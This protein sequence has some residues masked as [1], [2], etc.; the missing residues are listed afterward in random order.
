MSIPFEELKDF[1][2]FKVKEFNTNSFIQDDPISL[3]HRF[4]RKEDI[5]IVGFLVSTIAW[6]N[7]R[8]IIKSGEKLL[9]IM[10]NSPLNL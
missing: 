10:G 6:G 9:Y 8:A 2:E 4:Q 3:V 1:L 7:R 5:E